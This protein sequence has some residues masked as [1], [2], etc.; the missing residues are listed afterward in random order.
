VLGGLVYFANAFAGLAGAYFPELFPTEVRGTGA[1]FC[2]NVGR[3]ISAISPYVMGGLATRYN[4]QVS[5]LVCAAF[6]LLAPQFLR[7][8][9]AGGRTDE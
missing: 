4:L 2:F 3:G 1:G 9:P 8:L 7:V 6:F 5:L